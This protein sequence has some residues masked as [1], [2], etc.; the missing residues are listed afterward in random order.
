MIPDVNSHQPNNPKKIKSNS[1][2]KKK[3]IYLRCPICP[4]TKKFDNLTIARIHRKEHFTLILQDFPQFTSYDQIYEAHKKKLLFLPIYTTFKLP[5]YQQFYENSRNQTTLEK[6]LAQMKPFC[7]LCQRGYISKIYAKDHM[8]T[9]FGRILSDFPDL[10]TYDDVIK[11]QNENPMKFKDYFDPTTPWEKLERLSTVSSSKSLTVASSSLDSKIVQFSNFKN[12]LK[13]QDS[14]FQNPLKSQESSQ[15]K[16][17][18]EHKDSKSTKDSKSLQKP[19]GLLVPLSSNGFQASRDYL[20]SKE[21]NFQESSQSKESA[22]HNS[23]KSQNSNLKDSLKSQESLQ[24]KE[25]KDEKD[26]ESTKDTKSLQKIQGVLVPLSSNGSQVSKEHLKS[27]ELNFQ[28]SLQSKNANFQ[29]SLKS[30]EASQSKESK[31]HKDFKSKKDTK[32][33]Q[34][35]QGT[36][37]PPSSNGSQVSQDH[38]KSKDLNFQE[39]SQSKESDFQQSLKSKEA[40]EH[41]DSRNKT[42]TIS[43]RKPQDMLAPLSSNGSQT[44][45]ESSETRA[46][47]KSQDFQKSL[48]GY[49]NSGTSKDTKKLQESQG[50]LVPLSSDG[51]QTSQESYDYRASNSQEAQGSKTSHA[52]NRFQKPFQHTGHQPNMV[53]Q[54]Y[55]HY[56]RTYQRYM[57]PLAYQAYPGFNPYMRFNPFPGFL[58]FPGFQPFP[59]QSLPYM[60][61]AP[62]PGLPRVPFL[63]DQ[64]PGNQLPGNQLP[65]NQ[66]PGNMLPGNQLPWNQLTRNQL[67]WNHP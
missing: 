53:D 67:P 2:K 34:K 55:Q 29:A 30:Q 16:E 27:K 40:K 65:G 49:K 42:N 23:L 64:L 6:Y 33:L 7:P 18:K 56:M 36:L 8:I 35:S 60:P 12:S 44:S 54:T 20:Q 26:S 5:E 62:M 4:K 10:K 61:V 14:N 41:K 21:L 50:I 22:F 37:V 9:H 63:G 19:Q 43:L 57:R 11:V 58:P 31:D 3:K 46:S 15:S 52:S 38:S 28:E 32:S 66:L 25:S 51:F 13:S 48:E 45:Q 1:R 24:S 47:K 17:L 59:S 39:S